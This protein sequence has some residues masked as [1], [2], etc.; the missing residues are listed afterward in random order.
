MT[1]ES[2]VLVDNCTNT[3]KIFSSYNENHINHNFKDFSF[4]EKNLNTNI[5]FTITNPT[6]INKSP[7]DSYNLGSPNTFNNNSNDTFIRKKIRRPESLEKNDGNIEQ[8]HILNSDLESDDEKDL[9][10]D[11]LN[12]HLNGNHIISENF[13]QSNRKGKAKLLNK[14]EFK[15]LKDC[16]LFALAKIRNLKSV[17]NTSFRNLLIKNKLE[18]PNKISNSFLE[19]TPME[20]LEET[21]KNKNENINWELISVDF[22]E[23]INIFQHIFDEIIKAKSEINILDDFF[24]SYFEKEEMKDIISIVSENY[25]VNVENNKNKKITF[26]KEKITEETKKETIRMIET[27]HME[28]RIKDLFGRL[29]TMLDHL[30]KDTFNSLISDENKLPEKINGYLENFVNKLNNKKFFEN[31]FK[32]NFFQFGKKSK[33]LQDI[34]TIINTL[35]N[36]KE[37][38]EKA[39]KLLEKST[40]EFINEKLSD[41]NERKKFFDDDKEMKTIRIVKEK[42]RFIITEL[43]NTENIEGLK[44]LEGLYKKNN[45]KGN[46]VI[47]DADEIINRIKK[48]KGYENCSFEIT[49]HE[50]EKL[51][52]RT[53]ILENLLDNYMLYLKLVEERNPRTPKKKESKK[54][55][56]PKF[57]ASK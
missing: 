19:A 23:V 32:E 31:S 42:C 22:K 13:T 28:N 35:Y 37:K 41:K 33:Q 57:S 1:D 20:Y 11:E 52:E 44:K 48:L 49:E 24:P 15:E 43:K 46:I 10:L 56:K 4:L 45:R 18:I 8:S 40:F 50:N 14:D 21:L 7:F 47:K 25:N 5:R 16:I 27:G 34:K 54:E 30:I 17:L 36:N 53:L 26:E 3:Q 29:K 39:I 9:N 6:Y 2:I 51:D 12:S 38:N 55:K